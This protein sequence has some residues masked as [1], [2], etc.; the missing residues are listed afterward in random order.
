MVLRNQVFK[1]LKCGFSSNQASSF[2]HLRYLS[3]PGTTFFTFSQYFLVE[4][5]LIY[6][7]VLIS[8]VEQTDLAIH[9]YTFKKLLLKKK[10]LFF[11]IMVY[12]GILNIVPCAIQ[13]GFPGG[14][15]SK[16]PV[17]QCRRLKRCG[18]DPWVQRSPGAG[19]GNP[20]QYSCLE[21]PMDRRV[22]WATVQGCKESDMT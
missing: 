15:S 14:T 9:T 12:H 5:Q 7:V 2:S 20:L 21:N 11:S 16:E 22:W 17:C 19:H 3:S 13:Q 8:A 6:N 18:F 10:Q 1:C 4:V